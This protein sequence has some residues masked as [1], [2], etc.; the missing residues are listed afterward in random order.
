MKKKFKFFVCLFLVVF[1]ITV[2]MIS[3]VFYITNIQVTGTN[4]L[5][6][7][8]ILSSLELAPNSHNLFAFNSHRAR[9]TLLLNPYIEKV[10]IYKTVPN[11][12]E[13]NITERSVRGYVP[14]LNAYLYVDENGRVLETKSTLSENLPILVG[15]NFEEVNIGRILEVENKDS[16]TVLFDLG[17]T[18]EKYELY[19]KVSIVDISDS[20]NIHIFVNNNNVDISFGKYD[21]ADWKISAVK[22]ILKTLDENYRGELIIGEKGEN[23][24]L[25]PYK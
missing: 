3:P 22:E 12:L 4:K 10:G 18:L 13:I 20:G 24:L 17:K 25:S 14:Y 1:I 19:D 23:I 7:A 15:L 16:F 8:Q 5:T 2:L 21:D 9:K 11:K 6:R